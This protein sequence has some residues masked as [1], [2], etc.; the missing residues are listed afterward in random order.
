M[1]LVRPVIHGL[2]RSTC[3]R[4]IFKPFEFHCSSP[5]YCYSSFNS[6]L[7]PGNNDYPTDD[8][9]FEPLTGFNKFLVK[10]KTQIVLPWE[11]IKY[12]SVLKINLR[13]H[14]SDH[15]GST[16]SNN[17]S[18]PQICDNLLKAAYDPRISALYLCIGSLYC[19]WAKLDEIRRQILNFRKSGKDVVAYLISLQ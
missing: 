12:G 5:S 15:P 6:T 19:G 8:F 7:K 16:F 4:P 11:R 1:S 10:L 17:P 18:L 9:N 13:G 3:T 14:I 2:R